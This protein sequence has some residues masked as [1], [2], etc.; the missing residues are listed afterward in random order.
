MNYNPPSFKAFTAWVII[1]GMKLNLAKLEAR[2]Q[3]LIEGSTARLFPGRKDPEDLA[4]RLVEAMRA[5][6]QPDSQGGY[7]APNLYTI[8]VSPQHRA[9]L[10]ENPEV[11][12]GLRQALVESIK[13]SNTRFSG[14]LVIR[15]QH[16][17]QLAPDGIRVLAQNSLENVSDTTDV[18]VEPAPSESGGASIPDNAFLIV[19]GKK[20]FQLDQPV[21]N[22]G[23]RLDN[24][25]VVDD[26]R[27]SR[28]HAQLRSVRGRYV[29]FDLDSTGGT[30]VNGVRVRQMALSPGDVVSLSGLPMVYGQDEDEPEQTETIRPDQEGKI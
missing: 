17:S 25:L 29:I 6:I 10:Q 27:V 2:L 15:V 20:V 4:Y 16:D 19:D 22:I 8:A 11:L 7:L 18:P 30:F 21:I 1:A 26:P 12:E 24:Q 28:V 13:G 23:R 9:A 3:S 14:H 5:G